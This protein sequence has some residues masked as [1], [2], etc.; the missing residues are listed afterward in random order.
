VRTCKRNKIKRKWTKTYLCERSSNGF[1]IRN[2]DSKFGPFLIQFVDSQSTQPKHRSCEELKGKMEPCI[3][4]APHSNK[5]KNNWVKL[6]FAL[7]INRKI[8]WIVPTSVRWV[9]I[10]INVSAFSRKRISNPDGT[11]YELNLFSCIL[12]SYAKTKDE[13]VKPKKKQLW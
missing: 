10:W 9:S 7:L 6:N 11:L 5:S 12:A 4:S 13:C 2:P 8:K 3:F 1:I